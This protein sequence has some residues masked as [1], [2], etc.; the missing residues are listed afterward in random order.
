MTTY[1]AQVGPDNASTL[2]GLGSFIEDIG[3]GTVQISDLEPLRALDDGADGSIIED[4]DGPLIWV[5]GDSYP[6]F[7]AVD[8]AVADALGK[9]T[10]WEEQRRL[11]E[12][13]TGL[14][15]DA[16]R[17]VVELAGTP[18][19][20]ATLLEMDPDDVAKI[21]KV[22]APVGEATADPDAASDEAEEA[23]ASD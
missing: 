2:E 18:E 9:Q 3:G 19:K 6:L 16:V 12:R 8:A 14:R 1:T 17:S 7:G 5:D 20:A 13:A 23:E 4:E 22:S 10:Q 11:F 21:A 15:D